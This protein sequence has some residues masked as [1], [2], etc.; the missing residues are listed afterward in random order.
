M[1]QPASLNRKSVWPLART[2]LQ[3]KRHLGLVDTQSPGASLHRSY[4][5]FGVFCLI[6]K[7]GGRTSPSFSI[8][9]DR[10]L[11]PHAAVL[12]TSRTKVAHV[13][14]QAMEQPE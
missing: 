7:N 6:E 1:P 11:S 2:H 9:D 4:P 3:K 10:A 12:E 14:A 8:S 5:C 13:L